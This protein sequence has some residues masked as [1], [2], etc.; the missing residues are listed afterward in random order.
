MRSR[1]SLSMSDE[2]IMSFGNRMSINIK[3]PTR[4]TIHAA[5]FLSKPSALIESCWDK[6][7]LKQL[8]KDK[9]IM[10]FQPVLIPGLGSIKPEIEVNLKYEDGVMS[11]ESGNWTIRGSAGEIMK[12][13][14]FMHTFDIKLQGEIMVKNPSVSGGFVNACGWVDYRVQG[15]KPTF[16][17]KAPAFLLDNTIRFIQHSSQEYATTVF[18]A[19]FL[20]SFRDYMRRA[21]TIVSPP[22]PQQQSADALLV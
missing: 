11:L 4:E 21:P 5:H 16:F 17:R 9:Y 10:M 7:C 20:K 13:S 14:R 19:R 6:D 15:A 3:M 12:D 22:L 8:N 18:T 1:N 2:E